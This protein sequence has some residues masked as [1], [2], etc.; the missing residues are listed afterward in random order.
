MSLHFPL[1]YVTGQLQTRKYLMNRRDSFNAELLPSNRDAN[2]RSHAGTKC[3]RESDSAAGLVAALN[4]KGDHKAAT[5]PMMMRDWRDWMVYGIRIRSGLAIFPH[6]FVSATLL[7]E[8][9]A[10]VQLNRFA[11]IPFLQIAGEWLRPVRSLGLNWVLSAG[12]VNS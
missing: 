11:A 12:I 9:V 4:P 10:S 8:H 5:I 1:R 3:G 2:A 6:F 7:L